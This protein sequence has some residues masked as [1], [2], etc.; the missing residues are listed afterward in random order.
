MTTH[1]WQRLKAYLERTFGWLTTRHDVRAILAGVSTR[2]FRGFRTLIYRPTVLIRK[3]LQLFLG[4]IGS[5]RY[6]VH[7]FIIFLTL[8][9]SISGLMQ[10]GA[11]GL[12]AEET[13]RYVVGF[14]SGQEVKKYASY[15]E[16]GYLAKSNNLITN[17]PVKYEGIAIEHVVL[18]GE[19][20]SSIAVKY[21]VSPKTIIWAN[22]IQDVTRLRAG[23]KLMILPTS[24]V[25]H[26]VAAGQTLEEIASK[27]GVDTQQIIDVND[28]VAPVRLV[29]DQRLL[30]PLADAGIPEMPKPPPP[31]VAATQ[32]GGAISGGVSTANVGQVVGSGQF[33]WPTSG[34][35]TKTCAQHGPRDCAID[36]ASRSL[37]G[38]V[39][40]D[41]GVVVVSGWVDNYGYGNR[42]EI[43]H[44]NGY[45]TR[46]AHLS[47]IYVSPGQHVSKGQLIGKMGCTGR[48]SGPH[49]H[50]MI[51]ENGTPRDPMLFY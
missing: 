11:I 7:L 43:D 40:A 3:F 48:C 29:A 26:Q 39:A 4:T 8:A 34:R 22:Q 31:V 49:L 50:F 47:E 12:A 18:G 38:V 51:I 33:A 35:I 41:A 20:I 2:G 30:I 45:K 21:D 6:V 16:G 27:Y 14:G 42:V 37:P 10:N 9:V 19:T 28:L 1:R 5:T 46:Y 25:L 23:Q 15:L 13:N 44:G 36:I 24:G 17:M 32:G